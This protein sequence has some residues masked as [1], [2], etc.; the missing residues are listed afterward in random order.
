[1]ITAPQG[2]NSYD[3]MVSSRTCPAGA[4]RLQF[5]PTG[6]AYPRLP[7]SSFGSGRSRAPVRGQ[8]STGQVLPTKS[9]RS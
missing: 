1:M 7:T 6:P 4:L 8:A 2:P 5:K 3:E 9:D